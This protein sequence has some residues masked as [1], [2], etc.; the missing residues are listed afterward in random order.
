MLNAQHSDIGL[1]QQSEIT[2][3]QKVDH[4][5][6]TRV[7]ACMYTGIGMYACMYTGTRC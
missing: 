6:Q 1:R 4:K 3:L 5:L 2:E 7:C